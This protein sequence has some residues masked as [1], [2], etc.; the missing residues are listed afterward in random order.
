MSRD[1]SF[2][3]E[4]ESTPAIRTA[5]Q[6]RPK[7]SGSS[8]RKAAA[9][10]STEL[11]GTAR[12]AEQLLSGSAHNRL[13]PTRRDP[14]RAARPNPPCP[15]GGTPAVTEPA[16]GLA[17]RDDDAGTR[18]PR[19]GLGP[20]RAALTAPRVRDRLTGPAPAVAHAAPAPAAHHEDGLGDA[21]RAPLAARRRRR[22]AAARPAAAGRRHLG[23]PTPRAARAETLHAC[24][25]TSPPRSE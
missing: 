19:A 20:G 1:Q 11:G 22:L 8:R 25:I 17:P 23:E 2:G 18:T 9:A 6:G 21:E 4:L 10:H 3:P 24:V 13:P 16:P 7:R 12:R 5:L 15:G 14:L